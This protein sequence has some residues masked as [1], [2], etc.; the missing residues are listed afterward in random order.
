MSREEKFRIVKHLEKKESEYMRLQRLKMVVDDFEVLS[1]IGRGAFGEVRLCREKSSNQIFA[2][3]KLN[4][5]D[6][7]RRGQV[8]FQFDTSNYDNK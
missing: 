4:K 7:I 8:I 1:Q 2:M 5:S 3:K 6:M